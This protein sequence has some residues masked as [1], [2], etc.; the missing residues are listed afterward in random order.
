MDP[1]L[2]RAAA[3][4]PSIHL[5]PG[6]F[7][8]HVRARGEPAALELEDLYLACACLHRDPR[9]LQLF[10]AQVLPRID[11]VVRRYD[12]SDAFA[13]EV[14]Q[15]LREKL[16]LPPPRIAEYQGQGPLV[17]WLRAAAARVALNALRPERRAALLETDE[18]EALPLSAP[19]PDLQLLR[20]KHRA[21][22]RTAFQQALASL[23]VRERTALKLNALDGVPLEKIGAMYGKDKSTVSRWL[24]HA[25][26]ALLEQTKQNL[27]AEL[28]LDSADV[29]SLVA[30]LKSQ[31]ASS[32]VHLLSE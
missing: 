27:R 3:A 13:D 7:E 16:F 12:A 24:S 29:D 17:A 6:V 8:A 31:L 28:G 11:A 9:A 5:N 19:D 26:D 18:L 22:F 20:G 21:A 14:R 15:S 30:A 1:L 4:W 32:L 2:S 25:Q 23:P 10:D